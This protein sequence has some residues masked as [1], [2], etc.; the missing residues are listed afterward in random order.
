MHGRREEIDQA[1]S[2]HLI[3]C[4][5]Q[6]HKITHEAGWLTADIDHLVDTE[7]DD[8]FQ[9]FRIDSISRRIQ[10]DDVRFFCEVIHNLQ[11]VAGDE[12]TIVQFVVHGV[13]LGSL[14]GFFDNFDADNFSG[15]GCHH[16]GDGAGAGVEVVDEFVFGL[17]YI[18]ADLSV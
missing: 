4:F 8:F 10:H 2:S 6:Y 17:S 15:D 13:F 12:F 16:L 7:V 11:Y 18:F 14:Y 9:C 1:A 5:L 3:S